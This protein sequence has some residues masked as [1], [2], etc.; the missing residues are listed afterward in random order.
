MRKIASLFLAVAGACVCT[1][2]EGLLPLEHAVVFNNNGRAPP[3]ANVYPLFRL[4]ERFGLVEDFY[5]P[6]TLD[7]S[8]PA[9]LKRSC[10][11]YVGQYSDASP[12]FRDP[13][14]GEAIRGHFRRGGVLVF[15][16]HTGTPGG[17]FRPET[18]KFLKSVGAE[19]P[20]DFRTGYGESRL[21]KPG[22]HAIVSRP[23]PVGGRSAG[24]YGWWQ[25]WSPDQVVLARDRADPARATL[26]LQEK[27][28]G[29]GAVLFNQLPSVFR[30]PDGLA[31]DLVHNII[32][33]ASG[34]RR[35]RR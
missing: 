31:F 35:E 2:A 12:L 3:T 14:I 29:E 11:L 1:A 5:T 10:V 15:D 7:R 8:F 9:N 24:H 17:R 23:L 16:Y 13:A 21:E 4:S 27:V 28:L 19:P 6:S 30:A 26:I 22:V 20:G 34:E 18:E 33:Y 32:A 25:K